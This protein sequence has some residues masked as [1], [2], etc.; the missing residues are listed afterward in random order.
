ME[1]LRP[2]GSHT[3]AR[4]DARR[5]TGTVVISSAHAIPAIPPVVLPDVLESDR[6]LNHS[7]I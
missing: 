7:R 5:C 6:L 3:P 4:E 2:E 1:S